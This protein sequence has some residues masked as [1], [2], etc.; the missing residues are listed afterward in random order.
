MPVKMASLQKARMCLQQLLAEAL[1]N[2]RQG[3]MV[4]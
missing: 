1:V 3:I 2:V 4:Y